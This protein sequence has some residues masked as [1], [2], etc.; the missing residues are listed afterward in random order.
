MKLK[1]ILVAALASFFVSGCAVNQDIRP[2]QLASTAERTIC[3]IEHPATRNTFRDAY[4]RELQNRGFQA[5]IIPAGSPYNSC[6]LTT[7]YVARWSWDITIY[8]SFAQ[9]RVF[10]NGQEAGSAIYDA[11]MAGARL[12]K[13]IDADQKVAEMVAELFP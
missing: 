12:D 1:A 11:R 9:I 7:T 10:Q 2:V 13:W 5:Q 4:Q 3:I 8:M 6:P